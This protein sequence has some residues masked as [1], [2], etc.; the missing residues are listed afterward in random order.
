MGKSAMSAF[1]LSVAIVM[2]SLQLI[3]A[4]KSLKSIVNNNAQRPLEPLEPMLLELLEASLNHLEENP[5][6]KLPG[7]L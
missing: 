5:R 6:G 2:A 4:R 1:A 3:H 7:S